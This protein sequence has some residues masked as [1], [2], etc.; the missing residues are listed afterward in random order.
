VIG[1]ARVALARWRN[2]PYLNKA[3]GERRQC[4]TFAAVSFSAYFRK[5]GTRFCD[6]NRRD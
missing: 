4:R 3:I 2:W 1:S 6:Q 5:N